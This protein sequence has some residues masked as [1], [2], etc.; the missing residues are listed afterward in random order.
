M[1]FTGVTVANPSV[2]IQWRSEDFTLTV[3]FDDNGKVIA[4]WLIKPECYPGGCE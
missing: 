2:T 1:E 3:G 4:M